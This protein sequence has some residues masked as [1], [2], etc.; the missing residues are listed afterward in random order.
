MFARI[1]DNGYKFFDIILKTHLTDLSFWNL[2]IILLNFIIQIEKP[3][4]DYEE[5]RFEEMLG[6]YVD[7][8]HENP[9]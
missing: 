8:F 1:N 4:S 9:I 7:A 3:I 5:P 2:I 6:S